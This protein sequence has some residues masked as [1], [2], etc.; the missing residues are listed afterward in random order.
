MSVEDQRPRASRSSS[1]PRGSNATRSLVRRVALA[2]AL[3]AALGGALAAL[4][5]G[6]TAS[7]WLEANEDREVLIAARDFSEEITEELHEA[8]EDDTVDEHRHFRLVHGERTLANL[9]VH[10]ME[11][12]KLPGGSAAVLDGVILEA[13]D[14]TLPEPEMNRCSIDRSRAVARRVCAVPF[15]PNPV[16]GKPPSRKLLFAV[17]AAGDAARSSLVLWS[18]IVGALIGA[19][20]GGASSWWVVRRVLEPLERL[21]R[22]VLQIEPGIPAPAALAVRS[23]YEEIEDLRAAIRELVERLG[24]AIDQARAFS[25]QAAHELRTP[26]TSLRG[27]ID[28]LLEAPGAQPELEKVRVRLIELTTLVQR[29]LVLASASDTAPLDGRAVDWSDVCA[30]VTATLSTVDR[31]RIDLDVE[32]DVLVRG[33]EDLLGALLQNAVD[34]AL[35]FSEKTVQI[36]V[37]SDAGDAV[38]EIVDDGLGVPPHERERVFAP[39]YR[40]ADARASGAAGHGV[41]LA[42]ISHVARKHGG[43]VEFVERERGTCLRLR[44]P[45]WLVDA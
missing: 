28:L 32:Q 21:R 6:L 41:G 44:F 14:A 26:L 18:T 23:S 34:N 40:S 29:L 1:T 10:E 7:A 37:F 3:A 36:R 43:S 5:G 2:S 9:L 27:E 38:V 13:G 45:R 22:Q 17:S 42:L 8:E 35:K 20:L 15:E 31:A 33:D 39:F 24:G 16:V 4:V 12:V 25:A 30:R 11:D 19:L